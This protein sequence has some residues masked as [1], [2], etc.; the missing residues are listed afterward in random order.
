MGVV[1][2][3]HVQLACPT[4]SE[5][6][7]RGFYG[8]VLGL[9]EVTKPPA[10]AVRGGVWFRAGPHE[11]HCGVEEGF[12]P[13]G[14]A[15]PA[16]AVD[17][18]DTLAAAV[19]AAGGEVH[20]DASIPG[21]RR[22]HTVDPVG[23]RVELQQAVSGGT[24]ERGQVRSTADLYDELGDRAQS[25]AL[26]LRSFGG[27]AAFEGT[28]TTVRCHEDNVLLRAAV[29]RPGRGHVLVVDGGGSLEAALMGDVIAAAAVEHGWEGVVI[30]GAV[31]DTRALAGLDLGV[32][33]LGAN[34]RK[35][36]K[37]GAGEVDV[38][39]AFGGA[40]F[41]PGQH[42]VSDEDGILVFTRA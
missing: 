14:K 30:H 11:L 7:L 18:V 40:S 35:S 5:D 28:I 37:E 13:A 1:G 36:R 42:L 41:T 4:G 2:L 16:L 39:V 9:R 32:K 24:P 34:P 10:L 17:D 8:G 12:T 31:R 22:F 38:Q 23:N 27:R 6:A 20:W 25:C 21:V 15:H 19:A 3:H 29:G 26:Q 33:A